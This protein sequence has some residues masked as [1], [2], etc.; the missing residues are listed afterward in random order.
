MPFPSWPYWLAPQHLMPP[1]VRSAHVSQPLPAL[2]HARCRKVHAPTGVELSAMVPSPSSPTTPS[3]QH[4]AVPL[5]LRAEPCAK[6]APRPP[7]SR[8]RHADWDHR[9]DGASVSQLAIAVPTEA[10]HD[11]GG[12][13][14]TDVLGSRSDGDRVIDAGDLHGSR[15]VE[16]IARGSAVG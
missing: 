7:H 6:P 5:V 11:S 3:P 2:E 15:R 4:D 1:S 13:D 10:R 8:S 12:A 9:V 14:H 16:P